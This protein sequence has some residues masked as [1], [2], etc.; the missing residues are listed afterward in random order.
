MPLAWERV[1]LIAAAEAARAHRELRIDR[2]RRVDPFAALEASGVVVLRRPLDRLAG[3]Y[4]PGNPSSGEPAGVLINAHHPLSKQRFTAAHELA[5]HRKD[6]EA[7]LDEDTEWIARGNGLAEDRER[8]AEAFAS[9]FL[10]PY[11]LVDAL[12]GEL[13]LPAHQLSAE[14]VYALSLEMGTSYAATVG[15]L[16]N[17]KRLARTRR[18]QLQRV[19]PQAIKSALG[20]LGTIADA[21][22]NA[23]LVRSHRSDLKV[24][25]LQGD[26]VVVEVP[27]APSSGYLWQPT[28]V[29]SGITLV[30]DEYR[31]PDGEALGGR[32]LHRFMFRVDAPGRRRLHL[33]MR[34]P[35]QSGAAAEVFEVDIA[36]DPQPT[37]G[38][39]QPRLFAE[40]GA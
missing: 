34:R 14:D 9:W 13:G 37:V 40:S 15:H 5:H 1:Q 24:T 23:W 10:M 32:G 26:A 33:E 29:P 19:S 2:S 17:L 18:D 8:I 39:V 4:L 31:A 7:V 22:K 27:E 36:A 20:A 25:P 35:W 12:L 21:W 11:Q 30:H 28:S 3:L 6:R 16:A 38:L